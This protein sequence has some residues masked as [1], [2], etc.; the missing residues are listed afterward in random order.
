MFVTSDKVY[1]L[2]KSAALYLS[3]VLAKRKHSVKLNVLL[4]ILIKVNIE[5]S[6][7]YEF[8][9]EFPLVFLVSGRS[10]RED[11]PRVAFPGQGSWPAAD[12]N[13]YSRGTTPTLH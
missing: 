1:T 4:T 11:T 3:C 7:Y 10:S 5:L 6:Y 2:N 9:L 8:S 12:V 13:T